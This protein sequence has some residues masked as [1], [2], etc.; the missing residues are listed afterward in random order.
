MKY[1]LNELKANG[2]SIY[3]I[4]PFFNEREDE[5]IEFLNKHPEIDEYCIIDDDYYFSS[6]Y[7]HMIKLKSQND[8]GNGLKEYN[9]DDIIKVLKK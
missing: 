1:L 9:K 6:M 2:I 3:G 8:G 4:T 5:I 7:E